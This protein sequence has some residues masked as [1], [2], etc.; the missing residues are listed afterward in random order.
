MSQLPILS[1]YAAMNLLIAMAYLILQV[2][3]CLTSIGREHTT[4]QSELR[5]HYVVLSAIFVTAVSYPFLPRYSAF[6][7]IVKVWSAQSIKKFAV[8]YS[9]ISHNGYINLPN[10][11][12]Q[13]ALDLNVFALISFIVFIIIFAFGAFYLIRDIRRLRRI[14]RQSHLIKRIGRVSILATDNCTIPFSYSW[15]RKSCVVVPIAILSA[16]RD[17]R[18]IVAH[19]LQHHRQKDTRWV[20]VLWGFRTLF[21]INPFI[22]LWSHWLEE[23]QEFACDEALVDRKKV[24]SRQY[25]RCLVEAAEKSFA[26]RFV[27]VCATGFTFLGRRKLLTRRIERM[28]S[29]K[30]RTK[31]SMIWTIGVM[32]IV[33]TAATAFASQGLVQDRR[34]SLTDARRM[35]AH[36]QGQTTFP[37]VVND[38]VLRQLNRYIGTPEGREFMRLS[39]QRM[40]SYRSVVEAKISEYHAPIELMAVPL[41]ESGY[42]NLAPNNI[43]GVGAGIWMFLSPTARDFGLR[44]DDHI[45]ERLNPE[46]LTDAAMRYLQGGRLKFND[47]LLAL[48]G[49]NMGDNKVLEGI[50]AT[51]SRDAWELVRH[52]FENDSDYLA[53]VIA[54]ILIMKNPDS[55]N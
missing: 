2:G 41:I 16:N 10:G 48:L 46:I 51:G 14:Q 1:T 38:L 36:A 3:R 45:D 25:I 5:V 42:Q 29:T 53:K 8:Q 22:H 19:E 9:V 44:V 47:W 28:V 20:Y 12:I 23:I 33:I 13:S 32:A 21:A 35:A 17:Y 43:N 37:V 40:E 31:K 49:F 54:A 27:P 24:E 50:R 30:S 4:A 34:V 55:V 52:G 7:P 39:L 18:M 6:Q 11:N 15:L 26:G